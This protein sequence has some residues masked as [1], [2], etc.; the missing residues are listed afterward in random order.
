MH[1]IDILFIRPLFYL[2]MRDFTLDTYKT[3]CISILDSPFQIKNVKNFLEIEEFDRNI[4]IM[5]HDVDSKP[6]RSLK[7]AELET[8]LGISSTYYFRYVKSTFKPSI[9]RKIFDLG[10]QIG[11]HYEVLS[12][13]KGNHTKAIQMFSEQLD[14]FRQIAPVDTIC[15]HGSPMY[16]WNELDLWN[17]YDFKDY[18]ILGEA[19]TSL[20]FNKIHYFTDTG[21]TWDGKNFN[22]RDKIK[23]VLST[24]RIK[25]TNELME[26]LQDL[27]SS[28]CINTHPQ[29]WSSNS[30][31]WYKEYTMQNIKNI[32][33][34][35][36]LAFRG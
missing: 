36:L 3:L 1:H 5:R 27:N 21:R 20:D 10:H 7:M 14:K 30:I 12:K 29:R 8:S 18:Q 35:L 25:T 34:R 4:V 26:V 32:G 28:I 2:N 24:P 13:S 15:M 9:I 19:F 11:Y 31:D 22:I 23:T 16:K 17:L 6:L 33:K